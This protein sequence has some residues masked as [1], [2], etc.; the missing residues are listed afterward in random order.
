MVMAAYIYT[1]LW[2]VYPLRRISMTGVRGAVCE[3]RL[4]LGSISIP[5]KSI[6]TGLA[7]I[8]AN[9]SHETRPLCGVWGPFDRCWTFC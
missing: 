2:D 1:K 6:V 9:I 8:M 7:G 5:L 4:L 3:V